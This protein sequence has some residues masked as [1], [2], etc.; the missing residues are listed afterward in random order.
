MISRKS[1]KNA[2]S[3]HNIFSVYLAPKSWHGMD[4]VLQALCKNGKKILNVK[5]DY[6]FLKS[7]LKAHVRMPRTKYYK[8]KDDIY[9]YKQCG[10]AQSDA[11]MHIRLQIFLLIV[12]FYEFDNF[13]D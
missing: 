13:M 2:N 1:Y 7:L 8:N 9:V 6:M 5:I 3:Y 12:I 4:E 11:L 10:N